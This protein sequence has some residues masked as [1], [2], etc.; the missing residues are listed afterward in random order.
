M[1]K[2]TAAK[3]PRPEPA[4][5]LI[6]DLNRLVRALESGVMSIHDALAGGIPL[7]YFK[8]RIERKTVS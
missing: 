3:Q 2:Q 8:V 1:R 7:T 4:T 5:D 6:A